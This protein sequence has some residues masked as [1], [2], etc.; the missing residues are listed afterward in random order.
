VNRLMQ[1]PNI[2]IL[3]FEIFFL[4]LLRIVIFFLPVYYTASFFF[5]L[6]S[7][8]LCIVS[9]DDGHVFD[10]L[11][12][13]YPMSFVRPRPHRLV[14]LLNLMTRHDHGFPFCVIF[15]LPLCRIN[16]RCV[17]R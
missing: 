4:S 11:S 1:S 15:L 7:A 10:P 12:S 9:F 14:S 5:S 16:E 13:M 3:L 8:P 2:F 17:H 6:P